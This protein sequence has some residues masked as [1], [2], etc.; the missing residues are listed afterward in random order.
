MKKALIAGAASVALA[1]MPVVGVFADPVADN[2]LTDTLT[3]TNQVSCNMTSAHTAGT[4]A[5][6]TTPSWSA[7]SGSA[8]LTATIA[9]GT[10]FE[11]IGSTTFTVICNDTSG[12]KVSATYGDLSGDHLA[13]DK[14]TN[15]AL[16][17]STNHY[18]AVPTAVEGTTVGGSTGYTLGSANAADVF[19]SNKAS[20]GDGASF[21]MVYGVQ[22]N[23]SIEAQTYTGN[24]AYTLYHN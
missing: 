23:T 18:T 14:I 3:I 5:T 7:D 6:S 24:V 20:T 13:T 17:A 4:G 2:T 19:T 12:W 1:A 22:V 11:N 21:K 15:G 16:N 9:T 10:A 8:T